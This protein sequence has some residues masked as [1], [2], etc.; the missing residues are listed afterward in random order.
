MKEQDT[1]YIEEKLNKL[2]KMLEETKQQT[3][4]SYI[5][6]S[7]AQYDT[8]EEILYTK[9]AILIRCKDSI[10]VTV[11]QEILNKELVNQK[12]LTSYF[13]KLSRN[14]K[15]IIIKAK[16]EENLQPLLQIIENIDKLNNITT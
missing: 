4:N 2:E 12:Q 13:S 7:M 11:V 1:T 15:I 8:K 5:E 3:E 6:E 14:K 10:S 16:T 9:A